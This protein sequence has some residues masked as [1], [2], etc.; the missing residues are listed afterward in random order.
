MIGYDIMCLILLISGILPSLPPS[1][2]SLPF[3]S[4]TVPAERV[5]INKERSS[6]SYHLSAYYLAKTFS[7]LPLVIALP[8]IYIVIVYWAAGLNGWAGFFG[9]WFVLL[10]NGFLTQVRGCG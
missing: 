5:V 8:S 9:T 1:L 3:L 6:G 4:L 10:L 7:E 2:P